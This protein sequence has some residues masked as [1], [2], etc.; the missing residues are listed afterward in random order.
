M[1]F[2]SLI[3]LSRITENKHWATD[4]LTGAAI[5][6]LTGRLVVN[7][8]HRC[9]K[10]RAPQLKKNTVAFN[11]QYRQGVIMPGLIYSFR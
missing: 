8:Y 1:F 7:N 4:V 2:I 11:L 10:L 3:G 6:Y 9:A 5:G